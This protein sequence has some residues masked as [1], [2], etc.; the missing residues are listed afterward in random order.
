[1][2]AALPSVS[3]SL[4]KNCTVVVT[5]EGTTIAEPAPTAQTST[6]LASAR[7]VTPAAT[8]STCSY[9]T[10]TDVVD[11]DGYTTGAEITNWMK[12]QYGCGTHSLYS[13][14]TWSTC[15][16]AQALGYGELGCNTPVW[17]WFNGGSAQTTATMYVVNEG[18]GLPSNC[19]QGNISVTNNVNSGT[20][21]ISAA[22]NWDA[23]LSR[24]GDTFH[25]AVHQG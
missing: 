12:Y 23:Q 25:C 13:G 18:P 6:V 21:I 5:A 17:N 2:G 10:H 3:I 7:Q 20:W 9:Q 24:S 1:M 19:C 14:T 4:T 11:L 15:Y 22:C 8:A 16:V